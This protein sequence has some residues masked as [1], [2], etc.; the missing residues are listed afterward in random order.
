MVSRGAA[1]IMFPPH[2]GLSF[3]GRSRKAGPVAVSAQ[4]VVTNFVAIAESLWLNYRG[5]QNQAR[6][7]E[8]MDQFPAKCIS[9]SRAESV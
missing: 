8:L 4:N 5:S 7:A 6:S 1:A 2:E 3:A 9:F